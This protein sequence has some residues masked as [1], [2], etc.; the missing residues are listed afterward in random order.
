VITKKHSKSPK[1]LGNGAFNKN[2]KRW[3]MDKYVILPSCTDLN[4][5]DQALVWET[6]EI[7][8]NAGFKGSY[9]MLTN[10]EKETEQTQAIGTKILKTILKHP[11]RKFKSK[12]NTVYNI[13]LILQWG[14]VSL[15]DLL[16]SLLLLSKITRYLFY[17]FLSYEDKLTLKTLKECKVCF[18]KGGGFIHSYGKLTDLYTIYYQLFHILLAQSLDKPVYIMPNSF[19]PFSSP[20]VKFLVKTTLRRC[21]LVTVR[22]SISKKMLEEIGVKAYLFPDL[23]FRL[24][25]SQQEYDEIDCLR[26]KYPLHELVALTARPYRFPESSEGATKYKEYIDG[27]AT[28]SKWLFNNNY[29][30]VFL[31]HTLSKTTHENDGQA[32]S[33]IISE[34]NKDE[35]SLISNK[36][37]TCKD[38][39]AI[40]SKFNFVIGTRFHSVI[41]SLSEEIPSIA[42]TYGGNKG[43]GIMNDLGLAD[44]AI[45]ISEFDAV[46][47][48]DLFKKLKKNKENI[49]TRLTKFNRIVV[50]NH[51]I[52][53]NM[54]KKQYNTDY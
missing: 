25:K 50:E 23:G 46:K 5:G 1:S 38:L 11:S 42:I 48:I 19:G 14:F 16:F 17:P 7:A 33:E 36:S 26:I 43:Q 30:P 4:R 52:L 35:Y 32:I 37:Y 8:K 24:R 21:K 12:E 2:Y 9:Y 3:I 10:E 6:M 47:S 28:L 54:I 20:G 29:L 22:E 51:N 15:F 39:K 13:K 49:H 40:Y 27:M 34:L 44:Y 41:F 18:V 45:P 31:E 53:T